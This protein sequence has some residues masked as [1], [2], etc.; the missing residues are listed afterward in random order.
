MRTSFDSTGCCATVRHAPERK[1]EVTS[2]GS[3]CRAKHEWEIFSWDAARPSRFAKAAGL[4][5]EDDIPFIIDRTAVPPRGSTCVL[6]QI[7]ICA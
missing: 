2:T 7:Y 1:P 4:R 5:K 3:S 6:V